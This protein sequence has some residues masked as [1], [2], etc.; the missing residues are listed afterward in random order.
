MTCRR[1]H[2]LREH[3]TQRRWPCCAYYERKCVCVLQLGRKRGLASP[4][5]G[6]GDTSCALARTVQTAKT[7]AMI[8]Y[9]IIL[10]DVSDRPCY[11]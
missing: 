11:C 7:M 1:D 6:N 2:V 4:T 8:R 5:Y 10:P 3:E 9:C